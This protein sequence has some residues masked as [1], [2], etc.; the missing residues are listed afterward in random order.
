MEI[1]S[2]SLCGRVKDWNGSLISCPFHDGDFNSNNWR[3]G[4][5]KRIRNLVESRIE[6]GNS[7][8]AS[9]RIEGYTQALIDLQ[10]YEEV[11]CDYISLF[12]AWYKD[13]G[14]TDQILLFSREGVP[15]VPSFDQLVQIL[16]Y[17]DTH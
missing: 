12:V 10:D 11:S 3:C 14:R 7:G 2:C 6:D 15:T 8:V 5:I 16:A 4:H 13:R 1:V 17:F 9:L